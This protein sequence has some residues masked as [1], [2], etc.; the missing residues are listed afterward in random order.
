MR[1]YT[2]HQIGEVHVVHDWQR[3]SVIAYCGGREAAETLALRME[4][5]ARHE[6][7]IPPTHIEVIDPSHD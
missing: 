5:D 7:L 6:H 3:R 1:R 4:A 2:A